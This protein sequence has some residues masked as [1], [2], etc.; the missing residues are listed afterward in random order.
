MRRKENEIKIFREE[1]GMEFRK[2]EWV[3]LKA[4]FMNVFH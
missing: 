2:E 4:K 3:H 1:R